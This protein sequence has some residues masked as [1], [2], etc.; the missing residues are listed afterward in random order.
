MK[1]KRV[2]FRLS[3]TLGRFEAAE[4]EGRVYLNLGV[5]KEYSEDFQESETYFEKAIRIAQKTD[6]HDLLHQC[7]MSMGMMHSTRTKDTA[8]AVQMHNFA[9]TVA[10]RLTDRVTKMCETLLSKA[11]VL[12]KS[13]DAPSAKPSL[14]QAYKLK[15]GGSLQENV[16]D[17]L[18]T[19]VTLEQIQTR[20]LNFDSEDLREMKLLN[21]KMGDAWCK[22]KNFTKASEYYEK[23]LE[24]A[25]NDGE[26]GRQL[27]PCYVSLYET[28][29][30]DE[31]FTLALDFLWREYELVK[32]E[33]NEAYETLLTIAEVQEE[34]K[35]S[36]FDTN[37]IYRQAFEVNPCKKVAKRWLSLC[38]KHGMLLEEEQVRA[39]GDFDLD[40]DS[41]DSEEVAEESIVSI[42]EDVNLEELFPPDAVQRTRKRTNG[43]VVKKNAKGESQLH[44]AC[45]AGKHRS[46]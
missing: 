35:Y 21:E 3:G 45:I 23:M 19:V 27:I 33:P 1:S 43:F 46:L 37:K 28:Y 25:M 20:L 22:L 18:K 7:Y 24:C 2:S 16:E 12:V 14:V 8:K 26:T 29:K 4:M 44:Q 11:E 39:K 10:E 34:A 41:Q 17:L 6:L 36:F 38:Q 15:C 5:V 31:K 40:S 42:G 9:L 30:D 32:E 13:G